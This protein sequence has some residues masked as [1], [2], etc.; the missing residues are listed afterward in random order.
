MLF[1]LIFFAQTHTNTKRKRPNFDMFCLWASYSRPTSFCKTFLRD[2][3]QSMRDT[4]EFQ[5]V[6]PYFQY[7]L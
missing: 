7:E 4:N 3:I 5:L 1:K 2:L 6:V